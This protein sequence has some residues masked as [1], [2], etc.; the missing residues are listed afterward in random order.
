[1]IILRL[2]CC[3]TEEKEADLAFEKHICVLDHFI[4]PKH[5][6]IDEQCIDIRF[7]NLSIQRNFNYILI[8]I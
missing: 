7:L 6:D 4:Q 2:F 1:M 8:T 3:R 5:L